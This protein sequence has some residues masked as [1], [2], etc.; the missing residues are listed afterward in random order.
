M[1]WC[2]CLCVC[3]CV[4]TLIKIYILISKDKSDHQWFLIFNKQMHKAKNQ[5]TFD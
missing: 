2:V 3:V 5:E 1:Y 4:Y